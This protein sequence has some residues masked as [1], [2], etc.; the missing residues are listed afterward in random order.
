MSI[1]IDTDYGHTLTVTA[2]ED[3]GARLHI[4]RSPIVDR[5][6]VHLDAD[7]A[8]L[9]AA[10]LPGDVATVPQEP[11]ERGF[12]V[13]PEVVCADGPVLRAQES[14]A[15]TGPHLWLFQG[16]PGEDTA[17]SG[18]LDLDAAACAALKSALVTWHGDIPHRW[19]LTDD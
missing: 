9:L 10:A 12:Y 14:S 8:A 17:G 7:Q 1:L 16:R 15:A 13:Y 2:H 19:D 4:S 18:Q 6:S 5:Y 3:G 11:N